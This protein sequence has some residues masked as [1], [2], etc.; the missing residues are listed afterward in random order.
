MLI[1]NITASM[2]MSCAGFFQEIAIG[3]AIADHN[4]NFVTVSSTTS[5]GGDNGMD[6]YEM[7]VCG[8]RR[9]YAWI[10]N[11]STGISTV[12]DISNGRPDVC[13]MM[14]SSRTQNMIRM[15]YLRANAMQGVSCMDRLLSNGWRIV[16]Q[17]VAHNGDTSSGWGEEVTFTR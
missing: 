3:K 13:E 8:Q 4:C 12:R 15:F 2:M 1:L 14:E 10:A 9:Q 5:G 11:P 17:R 7:N 16:N 6:S